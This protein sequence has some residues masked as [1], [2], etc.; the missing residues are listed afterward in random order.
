MSPGRRCSPRAPP[1]TDFHGPWPGQGHAGTPGIP[2]WARGCPTELGEGARGRPADSPGVCACPRKWAWP[3][4]SCQCGVFLAGGDPSSAAAPGL[5]HRVA[6]TWAEPCPRREGWASLPTESLGT[7][8]PLPC[9]GHGRG[10][11]A[12]VPQGP[13]GGPLPG[14]MGLDP[15]SAPT[16]QQA[17]NPRGGEWCLWVSELAMRPSQGPPQRGAARGPLRYSSQHL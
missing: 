15:R 1:G 6:G 14:H 10:P 4:R 11:G 3:A 8:H 2:G 13:C 12:T 16:R 7:G 17:S 5:C 9:L